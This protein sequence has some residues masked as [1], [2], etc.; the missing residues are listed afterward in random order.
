MAIKQ[1]LNPESE[2]VDDDLKVIVNKIA[3][4]YSSVDRTHEIDEKD[5][6]IPKIGDSETMK[7]LQK[8][9]FYEK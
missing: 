1:F 9:R 7:A 6:I 4:S 5:V 8:L 3:K 2:K